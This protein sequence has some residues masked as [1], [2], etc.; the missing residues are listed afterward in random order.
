MVNLI[1]YFTEPHSFTDVEVFH[2]GEKFMSML[3]EEQLDDRDY[4]FYLDRL[5]AKL[6]SK[7]IREIGDVVVFYITLRGVRNFTEEFKL[8]PFAG[9][10]YKSVVRVL[11]D[12]CEACAGDTVQVRKKLTSMELENWELDEI[13]TRGAKKVKDEIRTQEEQASHVEAMISDAT[14]PDIDAMRLYVAKILLIGCE[15]L[16]EL[17]KRRSD[18]DDVGQFVREISRKEW[19]VVSAHRE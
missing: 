19:Q 14:I 9:V 12:G 8:R 11:F 1:T 13:I 7:E 6:D 5:S 10:I 18:V 15:D 2:M 17:P 4:Y 16:G 3:T